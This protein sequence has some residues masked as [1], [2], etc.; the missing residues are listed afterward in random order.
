V[1]LRAQVQRKRQVDAAPNFLADSHMILLGLNAVG[2]LNGQGLRPVGC[3]QC[4]FGRPGIGQF[5]EP[6]Q[7][8]MCEKEREVLKLAIG[9]AVYEAME[10]MERIFELCPGLRDEFGARLEKF[11]RTY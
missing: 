3:G 10:L 4:C 2:E 8:P 5:G 7:R 9:S 6:D 11:G 1:I